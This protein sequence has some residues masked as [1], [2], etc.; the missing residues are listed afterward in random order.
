MYFVP[1]LALANCPPG[2]AP[3]REG[4]CRGIYATLNNVHLAEALNIALETCD[5]IDAHPVIIR[6]SEVRIQ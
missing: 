5:G 6:N 3:E 2:L 4:E 1:A